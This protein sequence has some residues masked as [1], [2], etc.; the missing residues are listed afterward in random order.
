MYYATKAPDWDKVLT[1]WPQV[2][3]HNSFRLDTLKFFA[4]AQMYKDRNREAALTC[5]Q[6]RVGFPHD[7]MNLYN[8][9]LCYLRMREYEKAKPAIEHLAAMMPEHPDVM[10]QLTK[11][12]RRLKNKE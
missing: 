2:I 8:L 4:V 1:L 11:V 7:T 3:S 10:R 12:H 6:H 9:T 5:E